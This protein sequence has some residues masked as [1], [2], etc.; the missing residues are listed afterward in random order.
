MN[1]LLKSLLLK[2]ILFYLN[3]LISFL[4]FFICLYNVINNLKNRKQ[5]ENNYNTFINFFDL[6][7][8]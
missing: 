2:N 6:L 1:D 3:L 4:S 5:I 8:R 7:L